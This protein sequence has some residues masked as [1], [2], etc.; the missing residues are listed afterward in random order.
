VQDLDAGNLTASYDKFFV[1][2]G[3]G[4]VA[5][6]KGSDTVAG[7]DFGASVAIS[8]TIALVGAPGHAH[9]SGRAYVFEA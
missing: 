1:A 7:D 8:G 4:R 5:E 2:A 3:W 6:L 9:G